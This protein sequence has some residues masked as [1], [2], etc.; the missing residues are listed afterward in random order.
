M[1]TPIDFPSEAAFQSTVIDLA[2]RLG[3]L[4]YHPRNSRRDEPGFPDLVIVGT[5]GHLFRE[6]KTEKGRIRPEQDQ[7]LG[8]LARSGADAGIWR[9][10]DW[11]HHIHAELKEIR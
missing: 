9:P 4:V 6:L 11:P 5:R 10:S 8:R 2:K 7:W 1:T 3:L